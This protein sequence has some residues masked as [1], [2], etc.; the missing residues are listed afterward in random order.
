MVMFG[1]AEGRAATL[2]R[3]WGGFGVDLV[4]VPSPNTRNFWKRLYSIIYGRIA[5][6]M[7]ASTSMC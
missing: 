2:L 7:R 4:G 3:E 1:D 5:V 6:A